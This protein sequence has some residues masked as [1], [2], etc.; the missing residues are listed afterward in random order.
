[1]FRNVFY[2]G[3]L[4]ACVIKYIFVYIFL[5]LEYNAGLS[6]ED[7]PTHKMEVNTTQT[8]A[9]EPIVNIYN[10]GSGNCI[11]VSNRTSTGFASMIVDCGSRSFAPVAKFQATLKLQSRSLNR[12]TSD[13][14]LI[15][16][17]AREELSKSQVQ[18]IVDETITE[19]RKSLSEKGNNLKDD[20]PIHVKTII[21]THSDIDHWNWIE[22]VLN[23]PQDT[24]DT[25]LLGGTPAQYDDTFLGFVIL[26][27][28]KMKTKVIFTALGFQPLWF[29]ESEEQVNNI[30]GDSSQK[31]RLFT[32]VHKDKD[33]ILK[34]SINAKFY[35]LREQLSRLHELAA[36]LKTQDIPRDLPKIGANK[37]LFLDST[38]ELARQ[39]Y[40][41]H[42]QT[43][44]LSSALMLGEGLDIQVMAMNV[45]PRID[46]I[47]PNSDSIVLRLIGPK[48][49]SI[50][51]TGDM[52]G[53]TS[54]F[55]INH[56]DGHSFQSHALIL[57]HHG[58]DTEKSNSATWLKFVHPHFILCS[59]GYDSSGG[60]LAYE[61]YTTASLFAAQ[62]TSPHNIVR[63]IH[64]RNS[65]KDLKNPWLE[66]RTNNRAI[67]ETIGSGT[68]TVNLADTL[69]VLKTARYPNLDD[70]RIS[71]LEVPSQTPDIGWRNLN[72][73]EL[74][75]LDKFAMLA[76]QNAN[77]KNSLKKNSR[78]K[79]ETKRYDQPSESRRQI[80]SN[81][82]M[83]KRL[84]KEKRLR[85]MQEDQENVSRSYIP[86][87][88][89]PPTQKMEDE[90]N[91]GTY[92]E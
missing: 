19:I 82:N 59:T 64:R 55:I 76:V 40:F 67:Y 7:S 29:P 62:V 1:M 10:V 58:T 91:K 47:D 54:D 24:I 68:I 83:Q 8:Y 3:N 5:L 50:M 16:Q 69:P 53:I 2:S 86:A 23:N 66:M 12:Q 88:Q 87:T 65:G 70:H 43:S 31:E 33:F 36:I 20:E 72:S 80:L 13:V 81:R 41:Q 35:T 85:K 73:Q 17:K 6:M 37:M 56:A 39:T 48:G 14:S 52:T 89:V 27:A 45:E 11:T 51:L 49:A 9:L 32:S 63:A 46:K 60:G 4:M 38:P 42:Y 18:G 57:S 92:R 44:I 22:R 30:L 77:S 78:N 75:E 71:S 25:I 21:V 79:G 15:P 34:E 84:E 28:L 74:E 61:T 90:E 26:K